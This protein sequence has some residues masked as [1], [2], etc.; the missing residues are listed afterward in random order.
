MITLIIIAQVILPTLFQMM[1]GLTKFLKFLK[2]LV[3]QKSKKLQNS[4]KHC[5]ILTSITQQNFCLS[6]GLK[7]FYLEDFITALAGISVHLCLVA[8]HMILKQLN[9]LEESVLKYMK[10][11]D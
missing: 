7:N 9:S 5:L 4:T 3:R 1:I 8:H 6:D 11:K 10:A 2:M